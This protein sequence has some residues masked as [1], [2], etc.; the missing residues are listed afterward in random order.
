MLFQWLNKDGGVIVCNFPIAF[1]NAAVSVVGIFRHE[2]YEVIYC[3]YLSNTQCNIKG[4]YPNINN[5]HLA[6]LIIIGY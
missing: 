2:A 5:S 4:Y 6:Y 3:D 1:S